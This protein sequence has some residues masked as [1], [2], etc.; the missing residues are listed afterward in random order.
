M[1]RITITEQVQNSN[2]LSE[3]GATRR[4]YVVLYHEDLL[5]SLDEPTTNLHMLG[6]PIKRILTS[7]QAVLSFTF[8]L[9]PSDAILQIVDE[10]IVPK[11]NPQSNALLGSRFKTLTKNGNI[12]YYQSILDVDR[13]HAI[14]LNKVNLSLLKTVTGVDWPDYCKCHFYEKEGLVLQV[15]WDRREIL[16]VFEIDESSSEVLAKAQVDDDSLVRYSAY[17]KDIEVL[18]PLHNLIDFCVVQA[19]DTETLI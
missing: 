19:E 17:E 1:K 11:S 13:M 8:S 3:I 9:L 6:D 7:K 18:Q 5:E 2:I 4:P 16:N 10:V 14:K 12:I 15:L